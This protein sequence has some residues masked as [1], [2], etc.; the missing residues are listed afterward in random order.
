VT[1]ASI[2]DTI[3]IL[4][5]NTA[6]DSMTPLGSDHVWNVYNTVVEPDGYVDT[7][8]ILVTSTQNQMS[9]IPDDPDLFSRI[10]GSKTSSANLYFQYTHNAPSRSRIDPTPVNIL[11]VY[12]MTA[13]YAS[14]YLA[15]LRDTTGQ[16]TEP[17]PP[18]S[19][20]L[21]MSYG[22]L[23]SYKAMSDSL[24]YNPAQF[25][26][27]FGAKADPM[28]RANFQVVISP[29]SQLSANEMRSRVISAINTYFDLSNWDFGDS[30]YF[31]ELA[32]YLH[33]KLA[34]DLASVII[35]PA[36]TAL[37][38]G[39]YFQVNSEPW[40]IITSAA[41]VDNIQIVAAV[42]GAQLNLGVNLLGS[43]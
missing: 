15:W 22:S 25:K 18:T 16:L 33:T 34:P 11:D 9:G 28:L 8:K 19:S 1:S 27:L 38:F 6:P 40:E 26:P 7:T 29:N 39:N 24:V 37:A 30:F 12:I 35:V 14:D 42:T 2:T 20:S 4:K 10:V 17:M 32:A 23:N 31:S 5:I 43:Y 36:N 41:T 13:D 21:E 3:K